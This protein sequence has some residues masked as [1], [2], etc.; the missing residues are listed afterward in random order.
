MVS[1]RHLQQMVDKAWFVF[2]PLRI[3]PEGLAEKTLD[4]GLKLL[5]SP[6]RCLLIHNGSLLCLFS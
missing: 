1:G 4:V 2:D 6:I 3:V 5:P